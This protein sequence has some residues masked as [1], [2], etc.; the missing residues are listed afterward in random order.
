MESNQIH[1]VDCLNNCIYLSVVGSGPILQPIKSSPKRYLDKIIPI[2]TLDSL[3][4]LINVVFPVEYWPTRRT[5]G[6]LVKS[7]SSNGGLC[8]A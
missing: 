1:E 8:K 3:N 6:L 5:A 2:V 4:Y 7:A